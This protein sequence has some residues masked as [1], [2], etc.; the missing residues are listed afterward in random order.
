MTKLFD[1]HEGDTPLLI[2][3]PHD[4]R[5]VPGETEARM[6][7]AGRS[8]G[9]TDWHVTY[10]YDFAR[11]LGA[12]IINAR[13]S[14]YVIDLN[15][16]SSDEALYDGQ[17]STGLCPTRTFAGEPIYVDDAPI[18]VAARVKQYW[19]P[20]HDEVSATLKLLRNRH[21][22]ALL[23]DA[24]S[25]ASSVPTLFEGR[26]PVLNIGTWAGRSCSAARGEAVAAAAAASPYEFVMDGR[27]K[28]GYI[29][30]HYGRPAEGV[31]AIQLEIAQR[32]YM[33]ESSREYDDAKASQLRDTL[34][35]MLAAFTMPG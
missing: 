26:L 16:P 24:H 28:G 20:Y 33:N 11:D 2:S 30:R 8:L 31:E 4:G 19:Q 6:S 32:A 9:D 22:H 27:F 12:S 17:L 10:L 35:A 34:R 7:A 29:T 13:Y 23:W 25:I 18:D 14:R 21:G 5:L 15:R 3:V 1:L